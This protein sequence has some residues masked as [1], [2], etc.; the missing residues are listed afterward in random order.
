[1]PSALAAGG[2]TSMAIQVYPFTWGDTTLGQLG[3]G[4]LGHDVVRRIVSGP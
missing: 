4:E 1:M 3:L 2:N